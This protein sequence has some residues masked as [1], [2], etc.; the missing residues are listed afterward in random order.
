[1]GFGLMDFDGDVHRDLVC[2]TSNKHEIRIGYV[3]IYIK[4]IIY[5]YNYIYNTY[6]YSTI[7]S[8]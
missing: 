6:I 2:D 1:M 8:V 7:Y 3:Y 5:I 4:I